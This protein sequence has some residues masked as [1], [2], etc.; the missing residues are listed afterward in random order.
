MKRVSMLDH[1]LTKEGL[2]GYVNHRA[3]LAA[4]TMN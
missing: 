2:V 4:V 3:A 1:F